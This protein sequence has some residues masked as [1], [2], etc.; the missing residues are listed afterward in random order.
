M[1]TH[2]ETELKI[3]R[4]NIIELW[5]LVIL[6]TQKAKEAVL[7]FD[8]DLATEVKVNEK[9]VNALELN[10]DKECEDI[11]A[12]HNPVAVDLRF[13][14]AVLKINYNLERIGDYAK[15]IAGQ[16]ISLEKPLSPALITEARL[17]EMFRNCIDMLSEAKE[18]LEFE[19][20][21]QARTIF[22]KDEM[23]DDINHGAD[24]MIINHVKNHPSEFEHCL[25]VLKIILKL[26]RVGDQTK[27]MAEEIIFYIEAKVLRHNMKK[28]KT[29][30]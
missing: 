27:N 5:E 12:L 22:K 10:I 18:S 24:S 30:K 28:L 14:L 1:A 6:Q 21:K 8:K 19:N 16:I 7:K 23:L 29:G 9:R 11:L 15:G 3:L 20:N 2:L 4:A 13:V 26:E 17:E 25:R